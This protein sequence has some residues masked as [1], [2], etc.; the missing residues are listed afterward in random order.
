MNKSDFL[1]CR[2][3]SSKICI[4]TTFW[5]RS[6]TYLLAFLSIAWYP[7][8]INVQLC[9]ILLRL[10]WWILT[11]LF[12]FFF[13][14]Y[15]IT[16]QRKIDLIIR[17]CIKW[18]CRHFYYIM[19]KNWWAYIYFIKMVNAL[20]RLIIKQYRSI[21]SSLSWRNCSHLFNFLIEIF[22]SIYCAKCCLCFINSKFCR[23]TLLPRPRLKWIWFKAKSLNWPA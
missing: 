2:C 23:L 21:I 1:H 14:I 12:S 4:V 15:L 20:D 5:I 13:H 10:M 3:F 9:R 6:T 18:L 22:R 17:S 16:M 7:S 8:C 11:N 19:I